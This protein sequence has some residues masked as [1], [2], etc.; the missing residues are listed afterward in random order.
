MGGSWTCEEKF[1]SIG[2]LAASCLVLKWSGVGVS[3][4]AVIP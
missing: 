4:H 2:A 3:I 1:A